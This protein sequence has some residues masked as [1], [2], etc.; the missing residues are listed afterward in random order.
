MLECR[1]YHNALSV[2]DGTYRNRDIARGDRLFARVSDADLFLT[3]DWRYLCQQPLRRD[4]YFKPTYFPL[5]EP[6]HYANGCAFDHWVCPTGSFIFTVKGGQI[7]VSMIEQDL[8]LDIYRERLYERIERNFQA[9]YEQHQKVYLHFSGGI[10]SLLALSWVIKLDLADRTHLLYYQNM[11]E[12]FGTL[13]E[14]KTWSWKDPAKGRA[15]QALRQ[16][17]GQKF[18]GFT[19]TKTTVR[20]F[21]ELA[22]SRPHDFLPTHTTALML[23]RYPDGAHTGGFCGNDSLL[24][25]RFYVDDVVLG[26]K[27]LEDFQRLS[28][29]SSFYAQYHVAQQQWT[30][31]NL[32]SVA[33]KHNGFR[34]RVGLLAHDPPLYIPF[35]DEETVMDIRRLHFRDVSFEYL[36]DATMVREFMHRNV[37]TALDCYIVSDSGEGDC[38]TAFDIDLELLDPEIFQIR[39]VINH[40]PEGVDWYIHEKEIMRATGK[41]SCNTLVSFKAMQMLY[42]LATGVP[43]GFDSPRAV[44]LIP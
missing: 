3:N 43:D 2:P 25:W 19:C 10:D 24:H 18:L 29:D 35:K 38:I 42:G 31:P 7:H 21:A 15:I 4:I 8:D 41:V 36:L 27:S 1:S 13:E 28:Q 9:I 34:S 11:P 17:L 26:G 22:N 6:F 23:M 32:V 44:P 20:D 33:H 5:L 37:G 16:D 14:S 40:H 30:R 39:N 12:V